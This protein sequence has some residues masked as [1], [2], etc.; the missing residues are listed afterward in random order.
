MTHKGEIIGF[1][2]GYVTSENAFYL[3]RAG[4]AEAYQGK[5]LQKRL[6][7]VRLAHAKRVGSP[8]AIT[9]T[10]KNPASANNLIACGFRS[11][12]PHYKWGGKHSDYWRK[13][14]K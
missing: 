3:S 9:Y 1:A 11:Y 12:L 6:I 2:G 8:I 10:Y 4:V 13:K 5:G 14:L 7:R